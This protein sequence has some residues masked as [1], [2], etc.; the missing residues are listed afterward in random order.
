M[1]KR[2]VEFTIRE[3]FRS[4]GRVEV[5]LEEFERI[6]GRRFEDAVDGVL[7]GESEDFATY[8][9]RYVRES[10]ADVVVSDREHDSNEDEWSDFWI[11]EAAR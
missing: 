1:S 11:R 10:G 7:D 9:Q 2:S 8:L 5:N 3:T 4:T 6:T